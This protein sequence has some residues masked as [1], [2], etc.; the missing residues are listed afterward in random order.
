MIKLP[1]LTAMLVVA[2]MSGGADDLPLRVERHDMRLYVFPVTD[3]I[4]REANR[5]W[6]EWQVQDQRTPPIVEGL[7][8]LY[9]YSETSY[10]VVVLR[11]AEYERTGS[12]PDGELWLSLRGDG[13]EGYRDRLRATGYAGVIALKDDSVGRSGTVSFWDEE[14]QWWTLP[15]RVLVADSLG[16]GW[17]RLSQMWHPWEGE[18]RMPWVADVSKDVLEQAGLG[19]L[20][21]QNHSGF[22]RLVLDGATHREILWP[23]Y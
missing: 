12:D 21:R 23:D 14:R 11:A 19:R 7:F 15:L 4:A 3:A 2:L 1:T 6:S 16:G 10:G 20:V 13:I 22:V 5:L 8:T 18:V 9:G 17:D